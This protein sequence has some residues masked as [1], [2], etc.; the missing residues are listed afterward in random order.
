M[1]NILLCGRGII[2]H[3]RVAVSDLL[4]VDDG[5]DNRTI[6]ANRKR[7]LAQVRDQD[8]EHRRAQTVECQLFELSA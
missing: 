2:T 7:F 5:V 8:E 4:T 3:L 1:H 6:A